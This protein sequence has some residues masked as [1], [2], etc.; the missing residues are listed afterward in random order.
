MSS[1][2]LPQTE[3]VKRALAML[4]VR[5][6]ERKKKA[7]VVG[8]GVVLAAGITLAIVLTRK[9]A[10]AGGGGGSTPAATVTVTQNNGSCPASAYCYSNWN[11]EVKSKAP[12]WTGAKCQSAKNA[13]TGADVSCTAI[14]GEPV[15]IICEEDKTHPFPTLVADKACSAYV[16]PF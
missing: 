13:Q 10:A 9:K 15:T 7:I 6:A 1:N 2:G 8:T 16:V 5:Q 12:T 4:A 14:A 3:L 11:N